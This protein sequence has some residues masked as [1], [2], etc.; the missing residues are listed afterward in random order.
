MI[1]ASEDPRERHLSGEEGRAWKPS[2]RRPVRMGADDPS[3]T[4]AAGQMLVAELDRVLGV[5]DTIDAWVGRIKS[6]SQGCSAGELVL[7]AS[8]CM[9]AGGDFMADLDHQRADEA[10]GEVRAVAEPPARN[11]SSHPNED[12]S[13]QRGVDRLERVDPEELLGGQTDG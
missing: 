9:L 13:S 7:A 2:G 3:V 6:R 12:V 4:P 8:E 11:E 10:G 1:K 5:V